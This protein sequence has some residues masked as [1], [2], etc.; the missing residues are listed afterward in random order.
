MESILYHLSQELTAV[1]P[2]NIA[3]YQKLHNCS[4]TLKENRNRLIAEKTFKDLADE[5]EK[6][7]EP[8]MRETYKNTGLLLVSAV[9]D[10]KNGV[11][12]VLSGIQEW[13][14]DTD[15]FSNSWIAAVEQTLHEAKRI[16]A[17]H[18]A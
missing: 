17:W 14:V 15:R 2:E 4:E 16:A 13:L 9:V 11:T 18:Q 12:G 8:D 7:L 5:F 1:V 6:K 3:L 10:E